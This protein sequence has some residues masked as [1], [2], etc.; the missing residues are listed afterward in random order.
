M[1]LTRGRR[2]GR[3]GRKSMHCFTPIHWVLK[4]DQLRT[5]LSLVS[6]LL[7]Q[8]ASTYSELH[9]RLFKQMV[10]THLLANTLSSWHILLQ[11]MGTWQMS[12]LQFCLVTKISR[13]GQYSGSSS[14]RSI[15]YHKLPS[16]DVVDRPRQGIH[17]CC[18][19]MYPSCTQLSLL[20]SP[21]R[22]LT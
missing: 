3:N 5:N 21:Q 19:S 22:E 12:L 4:E 9:R 15:R 6:L 10:H 20:L 18:Q 11:Q 17:P 14:K 1:V 7:H 8:S 2:F 16:S 13:I